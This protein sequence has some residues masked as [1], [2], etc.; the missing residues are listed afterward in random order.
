MGPAIPRDPIGKSTNGRQEDYAVFEATAQGSR[1]SLA[2]DLECNTE[3][4]G[5]M[6]HY[7]VK[8]SQGSDASVA[9]RSSAAEAIQVMER[10]STQGW[11]VAEI[12]RNRVVIDETVLRQDAHQKTGA[13]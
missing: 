3:L 9:S 4:E 12:T 11:T 1:I 5:V 13:A 8:C 10:A 2:L 7:V 6:V